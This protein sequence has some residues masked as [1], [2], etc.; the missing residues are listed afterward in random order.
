MVLKHAVLRA[1]DVGSF[2]LG[3]VDTERYCR[4]AIAVEDKQP[5]PDA[6]YFIRIHNDAFRKKLGALNPA[7]SVLCYVQSTHRR[8][9][10]SQFL[11]PIVRKG[12]GLQKV[13]DTYLWN[14]GDI[15]LR[16]EDAR[17]AEVVALQQG[18]KD[19]CDEFGVERIK[20]KV[21]VTGPFE[22]MVRIWSGL[23]L[24]TQYDER[25]LA[26][27]TDV[28]EGFAKTA[29]AAARHLEPMVFTIDEPS[30][31]VTGIED[32]FTD[33]ASDPNLTHLISCWNRI[34]DC[35][36]RSSFR[37]L[38]LHASPYR[39]IFHAHWN[40]LEAHVGVVVKKQW[41]EEHDK[42]VRAAIM[43]TQGPSIPDTADAKE[44][45]ASIQAGD[46][47][48][49]LPPTEELTRTLEDCVAHYGSE[50]VPFAGPECGLG[51]W[52]WKHGQAMALESLT[53]ISQVV[54]EFNQLRHGTRQAPRVDRP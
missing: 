50:R 19:F 5:S 48:G 44:A 3:D 25:L 9:M 51:P 17:V 27:L 34:Y 16:P 28:V 2:P 39:Q 20:Y 24:R 13:Q 1:I 38:H 46:Y 10:I 37:G 35:I 18:A 41:L 31:G 21:C 7:T 42:F 43:R 12:T 4:G 11:D 15:R 6:N 40:L 45:W 8:D 33:A 26:H 49:Y 14:G 53:R 30:I 32:L 23:R 22:L 52:D 54:K 29:L 47:H 36:P